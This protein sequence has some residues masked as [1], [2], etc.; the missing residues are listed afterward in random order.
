MIMNLTYPDVYMCLTVR[1]Q[2][3]LSR[4]THD[5]YLVSWGRAMKSINQQISS[6]GENKI[7]KIVDH[8]LNQVFGEEA[9]RL[10]YGYLESNYSLKQDEIA[11][12]IN[13]FA[14]GLE[15]FL[16]SGAY[17]I[18][19]K[20]LDDVYSSY[21]LLRKLELERAQEEQDFVGQIKLLTRK[22]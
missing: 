15:E 12:K 16:N 14:K 5:T 6:N 19:R 8:I 11:E 10:I 4:N 7:S 13:V 18:E 22:A 3:L 20:I 1:Q 2:Y 17:V 9:T 21:G